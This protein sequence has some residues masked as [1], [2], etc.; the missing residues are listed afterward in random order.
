MQA[1][2]TCSTDLSLKLDYHT[3]FVTKRFMKGR[4]HDSVVQVQS[5]T[6]VQTDTDKLNFFF[7]TEVKL[8]AKAETDSKDKNY[9]CGREGRGEG[10]RGE[11][12]IQENK[13]MSNV[14]SSKPFTFV[15]TFVH[16]LLA[17]HTCIPSCSCRLVRGITLLYRLDWS[18]HAVYQ[19]LQFHCSTPQRVFD[20]LCMCITGVTGKQ[21][22]VQL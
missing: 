11:G 16:P 15:H 22:T 13:E 7:C 2:A 14:I 5:N 17:Q 21:S 8:C 19:D 10:E 6:S 3:Q 9:N 1:L 12:G 18:T 20:L 4:F